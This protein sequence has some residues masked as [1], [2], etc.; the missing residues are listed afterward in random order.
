MSI[1]VNMKIL[2]KSVEKIMRSLINVE[3]TIFSWAN[4]KGTIGHAT[5][6]T[7]HK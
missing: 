2:Y 3:I 6:N 1:G 7:N 4:K 5:K